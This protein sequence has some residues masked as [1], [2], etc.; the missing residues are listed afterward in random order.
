M[1]H[2]TEKIVYAAHFT[3][4]RAPEINLPFQKPTLI[5]SYY[6]IDGNEYDPR[7]T[8]SCKICEKRFYIIHGSSVNSSYTFS[9]TF[10]LKNHPSQWNEYLNGLAKKIVPDTKTK[11]QHYKIMTRVHLSSK[12]E[13]SKLYEEC[14]LT[15]NMREKNCAGVCYLFRDREILN[16][17]IHKF[18]EGH[19][20]QMFEYLHRFTNKNATLFD[21]MGTNHPHAKL[22]V[23]YKKSKWLVHNIGNLTIDL[24]RL[25][26]EHICFFDPELY[27]DCENN[28]TGDIAVFGDEIYQGSFP[29]FTDEIEKY[30]EFQNNKS[31]DHLLLKE[32]KI[33]E[34]DDVALIQMNRLLKIIISM[35]TVKKHQF[36]A[37]IDQIMARSKVENS[38]VKPPLAINL[39]GPKYSDIDIPTNLD[40]G[41]VY[42]EKMYSTFV[43]F[44]N[45]DCPA[46]FDKS[47]AVNLEPFVKDGKVFYPCNV[48]G[49]EKECECAPCNNNGNLHCPDHHLDHP[50]L[51]NPEEDLSIT[52]RMFFDPDTKETIFKRP[53]ADSRLCPPVLKLTGLKIKC[54]ICKS[55]VN[56][57]LKHH[58]FSHPEVCDICNHLEFI[59][60]NSFKL[61]CYV[62][63]KT[64]ESKYRLEDHMNIHNPENPHFCRA[65][66]RGFT[67]KYHYERHILE[68]HGMNQQKY[69][70]E[71]CD[72]TFTLERNLQRHM[73]DK[74]SDIDK[75]DYKCDLCEKTFNRKD[76]LLKHQ[77]IE[78]NIH[79]RKAILPGVNEEENIHQ[80]FLCQ[81]TFKQKFTLDRHIETVH[82]QNSKDDFKCKTC[83]KSFRRKDKLQQHEKTHF[84]CHVKIICEI[85]L[86]QFKS[87]DGLK[88]HRIGNHESN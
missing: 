57:H 33:V 72:S 51:F 46:F 53:F 11:F 55:N 52:R 64:F 66:D 82:F 50:L 2:Q 83:D 14:N 88:A 10:H 13:S 41:K 7:K 80:C 37:K 79:E 9:L 29:N 34:H 70:C 44:K 74:H 28:H 15:F 1:D 42:P 40:N 23:N 60:K 21:L 54:K 36:K 61:I 71:E 24:E 81:I 59:S 78:H 6:N 87:K 18:V 4:F 25:L 58:H 16:N 47:K 67:S 12:E 38:L 43:H 84:M 62:C 75:I 26:C 30:S 31:F 69:W 3:E 39:W 73:K 27:Q 17:S 77:R 76:N 86:K 49:C 45:E 63:M 32:L 68:N 65:C 19:N 5:F 22:Q 48:G 56:N 35:I 85:C 8:A 20:A